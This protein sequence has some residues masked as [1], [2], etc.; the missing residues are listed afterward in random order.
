MLQQQDVD[1]PKFELKPE[2]T[3]EDNSKSEQE[4]KSENKKD[5]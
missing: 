5:E 3:S 1:A 2:E 4:R